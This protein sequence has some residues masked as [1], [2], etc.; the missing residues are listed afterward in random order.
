MLKFQTDNFTVP[1][2]P[3]WYTVNA[4]LSDRFDQTWIE[5]SFQFQVQEQ[6]CRMCD[7][8]RE[9]YIADLKQNIQKIKQ[10]K[11]TEAKFTR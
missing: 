9:A 1:S 3:G 2:R 5:W 7:Q 6:A 4:K 8:T 11:S 10:A